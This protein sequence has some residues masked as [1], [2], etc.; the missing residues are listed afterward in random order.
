MNVN[1]LA[2]GY[3]W[4]EIGALGSGIYSPSGPLNYTY[5]ETS[6]SNMVTARVPK[7]NRNM[8]RKGKKNIPKTEKDLT[9]NSEP[10]KLKQ[11]YQNTATNLMTHPMIYEDLSIY[12]HSIMTKGKPDVQTLCY[13]ETF[14]CHASY[15]LTNLVPHISYHLLA[16]K[17]ERGLAGEYTIDI[18]L[19]GLVLCREDG[20]GTELVVE[21]EEESFQFLELSANY[22]NNTIVIPSV[23]DWSGQLPDWD[24][25]EVYSAEWVQGKE[26]IMSMEHSALFSAALYARVM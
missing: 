9:R 22:S 16:Y 24:K 15:S 17:G 7:L 25:V 13:N 19:C 3:H 21:E 2:S 1:F 23:L 8:E 14:C 5:Y 12:S 18:E 11:E 10:N 26:V 20:C 6:G 4:P